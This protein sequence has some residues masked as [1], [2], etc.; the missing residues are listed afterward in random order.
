MRGAVENVSAYMT[1]LNW[2]L[3]LFS[4]SVRQMP[5]GD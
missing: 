5:C 1:D 4:H 3:N 2:F